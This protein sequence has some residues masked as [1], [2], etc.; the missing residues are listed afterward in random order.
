MHT[1]QLTVTVNIDAMHLFSA[2]GRIEHALRGTEG[3]RF[4]HTDYDRDDPQNAT[5][6]AGAAALLAP[7]ED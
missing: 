1:Y 3:V 2:I 4:V 6:F 7:A 5:D